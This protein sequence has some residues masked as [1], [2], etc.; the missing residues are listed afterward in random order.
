MKEILRE[1]AERTQER[2]AEEGVTEKDVEA[3]IEWVRS[4][5]E[6]ED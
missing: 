6:T 5:S 3:A 4:S 1:M 2:F